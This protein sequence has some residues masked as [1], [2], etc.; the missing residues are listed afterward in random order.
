[1]LGS[2]TEVRIEGVR[3]STADESVYRPASISGGLTRYVVTTSSQIVRMNK[4]VRQM[5]WQYYEV[6]VYTVDEMA[7]VIKV[8][9]QLQEAR[10]NSSIRFRLD[11]DTPQTKEAEYGNC[12][13][14]AQEQATKE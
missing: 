12:T 8:K 5:G 6:I 9:R 13:W 2:V 7:A 3:A 1:M 10:P 11:T 4:G 14:D